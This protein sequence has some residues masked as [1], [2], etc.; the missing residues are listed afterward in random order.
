MSIEVHRSY[1]TFTVTNGEIATVEV[2]CCYFAQR[3]HFMGKIN[4]VTD[5]HYICAYLPLACLPAV[6]DLPMY[7]MSSINEYV[8]R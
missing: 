8:S 1:F 3:E 4:G 2:L 7:S 6:H 5:Q